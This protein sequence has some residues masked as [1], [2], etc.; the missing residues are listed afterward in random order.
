ML[1]LEA[2]RKTHFFSSCDELTRPGKLLQ[3]PVGNERLTNKEAKEVPVLNQR[4]AIAPVT[5]LSGG[6]LMGELNK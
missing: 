5:G 4:M 2:V 1:S 3:S 6:V